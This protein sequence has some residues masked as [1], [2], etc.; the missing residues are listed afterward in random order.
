M[1]RIFLAL[2]IF[3]AATTRGEGQLS[4]P[5]SSIPGLIY[6]NCR[7][8]DIPWS[9][10][11][12]QW[13]RSNPL[14]EIHSV[15]AGGR[16]AV[17]LE[18][19][20][21]QVGLL[22]SNAVAAINGDFY[23]RDK[24]YAGVPHGLQ[25]IDGEVISAP[26]GGTTFWV[27]ALGEPHMTNIVSLFQITWPNAL[28]STFGLN[29]E[30]AGDAIELYTSAAGSSTH[31]VGGRELVLELEQGSPRLPLRMGRVYI[32]RV[33]DIREAGDT[34]LT[35]ELLVLSLSPI[36]AQK[37]PNVQ[38]GTV[39]SINIGS[40]P[41]L[42]GIRTAISGGPVLLQNG[43]RQKIPAPTLEDYEFSST[44]ERHPRSALGWNDK[45]FYLVEVDGR[46]RNL[47]VGMTLAE[48]SG[49]LKKLGC[50]EAMNLDG[51]GSATLWFNGKVRNS[52]CDR[53]ERE[54]SN[55]LVLSRKTR[56]NLSQDFKTG[57]QGKANGKL[58]TS[59]NLKSGN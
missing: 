26:L 20:S 40:V 33:R 12:I 28:R 37:L 4:E 48:L 5:A 14:Y 18:T 34:P 30:R 31:T 21:D 50:N 29:G 47:S 15:H 45:Y 1:I 59:P 8:A 2:L 6:T 25:V 13:D 10:H 17:G 11:I 24:A 35:P 19:L 43:R 23:Q 56:G 39:L 55:C 38:I 22:N 52:P 27:D 44:L 42:Y 51:G 49:F 36:A 7:I 46:Q 53:A 54:V 32:A 9:I 57:M 58:S 3:G 41:A 16:R